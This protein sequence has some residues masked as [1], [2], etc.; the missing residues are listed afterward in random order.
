[1]TEHVAA[2]HGW[3][4]VIPAEYVSWGE[5]RF[6]RSFFEIPDV[7]KRHA[8]EYEVWLAGQREKGNIR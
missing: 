7:L 6:Y 8:V 5:P 2:P 3:R 4:W 1:M